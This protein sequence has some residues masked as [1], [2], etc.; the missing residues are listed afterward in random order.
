MSTFLKGTLEVQRGEVREGELAPLE[1]GE[2]VCMCVHVRVC[3][4]VC[5]CVCVCVC[6]CMD[7]VQVH[8]I[9]YNMW[10]YIAWICCPC[11]SSITKRYK[12]KL[13]LSQGSED[14]P[15]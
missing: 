12:I 15:E 9:Q 3:V 6:V 8:V 4:H 7:V 5:M 13:A 14:M 10:C 1:P 11:M 2:S